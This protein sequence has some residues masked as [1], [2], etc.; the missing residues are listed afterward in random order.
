MIQIIISL[1]LSLFFLGVARLITQN[2]V[3]AIVV[4]IFV[5]IFSFVGLG[6][7]SAASYGDDQ[8]TPMEK[9]RVIKVNSRP[10]PR[11]VGFAEPV[12]TPVHK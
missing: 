11:L 9:A 1:F 12:T 6:M 10:A 2:W 8:E 4:A 5:L 3:A 7:T